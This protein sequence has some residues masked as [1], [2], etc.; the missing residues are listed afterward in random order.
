ME[1]FIEVLHQK[2]KVEENNIIYRLIGTLIALPL[3]LVIDTTNKLNVLSIS[4]SISFL[5]DPL[6][7]EVKS[8]EK[9]K[10][11]VNSFVYEFVYLSDSIVYPFQGM[12]ITYCPK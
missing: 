4:V 11:G 2:K 10:E 12:N 1:K 5:S 8:Q 3:T 6:L 9:L 7:N